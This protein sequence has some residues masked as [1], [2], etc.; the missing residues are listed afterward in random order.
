MAPC[1]YRTW[2][3]RTLADTLAH[4]LQSAHVQGLARVDAQLLLMWALGRN[5]HDRAWLLAHDDAV[6]PETAMARWQ[7]AL[8][9]RLGGEPVAYIVGEQAFYGLTLRVGPSVLVPRADTETLVQW[10]LDTAPDQASFRCCDLGTGSGAIALALCHERPQWSITAT[11]RSADALLV[12]QANAERLGL[13]LRWAHG[14]WLAA[15]P[16]ERFD[17]IVSNPPYIAEGDPHLK[18]LRHEPLSALTAGVDGLDDLRSLIAQAPAHL[19]VGAWLLL[20]HGHDQ[21][22]AV[23]VLLTQAGFTKV[24]SR[25]DLAGIER[26][27]GGRWPNTA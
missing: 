5:P 8:H 26:C 1:A 10:A 15:L 23:R 20:E 7:A 14:P 22:Q 12:A 18:A 13:R 25:K 4:C 11:D 6:L 9:R 21:A 17:L 2:S 3:K 16:G 24:N 19:N 27:S